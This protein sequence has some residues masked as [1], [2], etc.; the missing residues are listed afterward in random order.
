MMT[1]RI[2][3][4][5]IHNWLQSLYKDNFKILH[6]LVDSKDIYLIKNDFDELC[7]LKIVQIDFIDEERMRKLMAMNSEGVER[8]LHFTKIDEYVVVIKSF[9]SGETLYDVIEENGPKSEKQVIEWCKVIGST[10]E[11]LHTEN[12]IY[13]DI[14]PKN[15]MIDQKNKPVLIDIESIRHFSKEKVTDTVRIGAIGFIAPEQYGFAQSDQRSDI[16]SLGVVMYY[17]L[18][19]IAPDFNMNRIDLEKLDTTK[20]LKRILGKMTN[21]SP[22]KRYR[23][24]S[25][26]VNSIGVNERFMTSRFVLSNFLVGLFVTIIGVTL[27]YIISISL[28]NRMPL[29]E[30]VDLSGYEATEVRENIDDQ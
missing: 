18:V 16:Y 2:D 20:D 25:A 11:Y 27:A 4:P 10:L 26:V 17:A 15:I 9:I 30:D 19:G 24:M 14:H 1:L 21:F 6:R 13:R 29:V 22:D 3:D 12:F 8:I 7:V 23:S 5:R 28:L